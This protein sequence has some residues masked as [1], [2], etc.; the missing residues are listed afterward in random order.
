MKLR[1]FITGEYLSRR[2]YLTQRRKGA[3]AQS[4]F[5]NFFF[6]SL[7]LCVFALILFHPA[8]SQKIAVLTPDETVPSQ[9]F[10]AEIE[11]KLSAGYA[12]LDAS[13]SKTAF[14]S[15]AFEIENPFN[16]SVEEA[17]NVGRAIGCHYFLLVKHE[18]LR[19]ASLKKDDYYESYA[20]VFAVNSRTGNLVFWKLNSFEADKPSEAEKKLYNSIPNLANEIS[21]G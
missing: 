20:V 13:L 5:Y 14:R 19:R 16:L 8:F 1:K 12:V 7:R 6:A 15:A 4:F 10:A 17:V 21:D 2:K 9:N 11:K 3:A 18:T